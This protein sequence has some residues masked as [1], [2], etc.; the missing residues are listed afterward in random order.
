MK[1]FMASALVGVALL[2]ANVPATASEVSGRK[3]PQPALVAQPSSG[4]PDTT[5]QRG[6]EQKMPPGAM[7][8]GMMGQSGSMKMMGAAG[9]DDM[10]PMM[11]M[12]DMADHVE[13]RIAFL[14]TE[15]KI[16]DAQTTQWNAFADALRANARTMMRMHSEMKGSPGTAD[17]MSATALDRLDRMQKHMSASL[18]ALKTMDAALR[19]LYAVLS[20][21][22]KKAADALIAPMKMM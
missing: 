3:D 4:Q 8:G 12:A 20:D 22:Q 5:A 15:L 1:V 9:H 21:E 7:Q 17:M 6:M 2:V 14:K 10:M 11:G 16:T 18:D 13:G 19:P